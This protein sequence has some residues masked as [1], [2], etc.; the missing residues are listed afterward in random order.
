MRCKIIPPLYCISQPT[1]YYGNVH[2]SCGLEFLCVCK[3]AW[4]CTEKLRRCW[5]ISWCKFLRHADW[6]VISGGNSSLLLHTLC[7]RIFCSWLLCCLR[8][9]DP[10]HIKAPII[11][12]K[13]EKGNIR[14]LLGNV[15]ISAKFFICITQIACFFW[16]STLFICPNIT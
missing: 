8:H 6:N 15:K 5:K 14:F 1:L 12:W 2:E 4:C 13:Q 9:S 16:F 7:S 3:C 11:V 10:V